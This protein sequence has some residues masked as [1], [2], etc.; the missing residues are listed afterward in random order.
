MVVTGRR[1][2]RHNQ[3]LDD[4]EEIRGYCKLK[5]RH[6]IESCGKLALKRV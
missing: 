5:R 3:P 6:L 1:G 2:R 4:L